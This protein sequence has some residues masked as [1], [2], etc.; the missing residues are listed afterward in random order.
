M[1]GVATHKEDRLRRDIISQLMSYYD[2]KPEK[3]AQKHKLEIDFTKE[4]RNLRF[5]E[6]MGY[7]KSGKG[8]LRVTKKG[9][10]FVRGI[11]TV[12]DPHFPVK[13]KLLLDILRD[14]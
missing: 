14:E 9:R 11:A 5:L 2:V 1:R 3:V 10:P 12:F 13:G 4:W 7:I 6:D 8:H